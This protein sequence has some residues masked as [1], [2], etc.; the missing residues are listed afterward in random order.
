M[1][2]A[3]KMKLKGIF[4]EIRKNKFSYAFCFP[5][6]FLFLIFTVLPVLV[7]I[8]LSFTSFNMLQPPEFLGIDNY[9]R[10]FFGDQIFL[11]GFKNT[12]L[13][14]LIVGPGGYLL[15][16]L[17]A[18]L[19][20]E[21]SPKLR[22]FVT[23]IFYAPSISG[24]MYLIWSVMFSGDEYGYINSLLMRLDIITEPVRWLKNPQYTLPIVI[25][26]SLWLSL[27]TS[28][29]AFIAGFQGVSKTYYEAAAVDGV[30]NRW[31]EL[32]FVT[33][34]MMRP[35]MMFS[36]VMSITGAFN[37]GSVVTALCGLPSVDYSAHTIMNHLEDFGGT[38]FEMGY[39]SAIATFLFFL[40]IASNLVIKKMISKV[41]N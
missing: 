3:D 32:W 41:G 27:G 17:M 13:I 19:I 40:M 1:K 10:M 28:F 16:M 15:C 11:T 30:K 26:V 39:A 35:Q 22:A 29:L 7:S 25:I 21:L 33:L 6:Y 14:A 2:T 34:P 5:Y 12:V 38:R 23:L 18:W 8:F 4:K 20:N 24:N 9:I 36:A 31:Q 37:V